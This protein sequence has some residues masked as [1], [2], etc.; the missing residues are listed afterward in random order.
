MGGTCQG[1]A[2][3]LPCRPWCRTA[4][5][6]RKG[7]EESSIS[8]ACIMCSSTSY[9]SHISWLPCSSGSIWGCGS[10][11]SFTWPMLCWG[12]GSVCKRSSWAIISP[13]G[14]F[15]CG[16]RWRRHWGYSPGP[17]LQYISRRYGATVSKR[18]G[19]LSCRSPSS[20]P[21]LL[22]WFIYALLLGGR[23]SLGWQGSK[24]ARATVGGFIVVL[25]S[26]FVHTL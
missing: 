6:R 12:E 16:G 25:A 18:W 20:L 1:L 11:G 5:G 23:R 19:P 3:V 22:A 8:L 15:R 26:Y 9:C 17:S 7:S 13:S 2:A 21:L 4:L 14:R 24:A 10:A